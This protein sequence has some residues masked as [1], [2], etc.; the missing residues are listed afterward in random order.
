MISV[1]SRFHATAIYKDDLQICFLLQEEREVFLCSTCTKCVWKFRKDDSLNFQYRVDCKIQSGKREKGGKRDRR[2]KE[3]EKQGARAGLDTPSSSASDMSEEVANLKGEVGRLEAEIKRLKDF[4]ENVKKQF[5]VDS[6][7]GVQ[8][9][10][11]AALE[12]LVKNAGSRDPDNTT[13]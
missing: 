13:N 8:P 9:L 7:V 1:S 10:K 12:Y 4:E 11:T 6:F 3:Q 5:G 2:I